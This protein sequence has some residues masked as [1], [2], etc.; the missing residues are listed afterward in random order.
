MMK[1]RIVL[2][3]ALALA[4][5]FTGC[6]RETVDLDKNG[7]VKE[8]KTKFVF[9]V[10]TLSGK[11][12]KQTAAQTQAGGSDFRGIT[13]ARLMTMARPNEDGTILVVDADVDHVYDFSNLVRAGQISS[14]NSRRVLEMSLPLNT[15]TL[16]FYGRA[17]QSTAT[18]P[19]GLTSYDCYGHL[20]T[21][22]VSDKGGETYFQLGKRLETE[23][24]ALFYAAEKLI[25]GIQTLVMNTNLAGSNHVSI[26]ADE[27]PTGSSTEGDTKQ[28]GY[29][30]DGTKYTLGEGGY[31][32]IFWSDYA[33]PSKKSPVDTDNNLYPL[34]EKLANLYEE[35]TTIRSENNDELRAGSGEA[36]IRIIQDLWTV[37]NSVRCADPTCE[38]EAVAKFF[39]EKV[40]LRLKDYFDATVPP[41]G[42][43]VTVNGFQS[44]ATIV[45]KFAADN[46]WPSVIDAGTLAKLK[47]TENE[48]NS[49]KE[50]TLP[51]KLL[52][53][54][55][56]YF[57][58]PVGATYLEFD[59]GKKFF[60]Y[61]TEFNTSAMGKGGPYNAENYFYPAE[62]LYFANS[63]LRASD[64]ERAE[65][66]FPQTS[67]DW[68]N[69]NNAK[70][71]EKGA[72]D[73]PIWGD[74][75][76]KSSTRSVAMIYD[77]DYGVSMLETKVGYKTLEL[78]DN[79]HAVMAEKGLSNTEEDQVI[80]V[81]DASFLFT[82]L[83]IGGQPQ[84]V[85]WNFLPCTAPEASTYKDG[86]LY[87][88]AVVNQSIP[89]S[90][91]LTS[92]PNYTVVFD[93]F[94]ASSYYVEE[95]EPLPQ[96]KVNVALEF[97]N[98]SGVDFYGNHNLIRNGGHF[99]LVG[100]LDPNMA[101]TGITWP[102]QGAIVPPYTSA[103]ESEKVTRV[104]VQDYKTTV[105]FKLGEKSLQ[106]AY[107]TVPDLRASSLTLGLS[108]D[109]VWQQGLVYNEVILGGNG[110]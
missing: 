72:D 61:P 42:K 94:N 46:N 102:T 27:K 100:E 66:D 59:E 53:E 71:K 21:Y 86:F 39:A 105:T 103:G 64:T 25:A 65:S 23:K 58:L 52:Y 90:V 29:S 68:N 108:V 75:H 36:T 12:T 106:Y 13:D 54:F 95:G 91:S 7:N 79:R 37:I 26:S 14:S 24:T 10:S 43:P 81:S 97:L 35:M 74:Q 89:N 38:A 77:I 84:H 2:L 33:N 9:N 49:L 73:N 34:E 93:N 70:W 60:S 82:G 63:P 76:V 85:G 22:N 101:G 51:A 28:Y 45:E 56:S 40:N 20:D 17:A 5:G 6:Q 8:V 55:P 67:N 32:Q 11:Q 18:T 47:L 109:I 104:F 83:I 44:K 50:S 96:D 16:I 31:P 98:N 92:E 78:K 1:K 107:I 69:P 41:S 57:N 62:L 19:D 4:A 15:N 88:K 30:F 3:M 87:D 80:K 48:Q 110:N 99:Y